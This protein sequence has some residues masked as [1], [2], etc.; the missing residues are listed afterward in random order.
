M[1]LRI[2]SLTP[3]L[4]NEPEEKDGL[5]VG[6]GYLGRLFSSLSEHVKFSISYFPI[7]DFACPRILSLITSKSSTHC[8]YCR[9]RRGRVA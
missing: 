5:W 2:R 9:E 6:E 8:P 4:K 1:K 7:S 3:T